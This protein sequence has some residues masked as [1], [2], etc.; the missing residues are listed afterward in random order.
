MGFKHSG[1]VLKFTFR[2]FHHE[3]RMTLQSLI[4][5]FQ[6]MMNSLTQ[7]GWQK[8]ETSKENDINEEDIRALFNMIDKDK[9]GSLSLRVGLF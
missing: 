9:S 7:L 4:L 8:V 1:W 2:S 5:S 3:M 6:K